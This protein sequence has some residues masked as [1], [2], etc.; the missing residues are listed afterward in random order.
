MSS[1]SNS[2]VTEEQSVRERY[3][4]ASQEAEPALCCPVEYPTELLKIIPAEIIER[5]Y[6]CGDPSP[7]V[8]PGDT[9]LDLGSGG[10]KLC[11][12]AA[13][14]VGAEGKVIGVDCNPDMLALARKYQGE[15]AE[16]IGHANVEF[17]C[18]MIQDLG[19]DLERLSSQLAE[20]NLS[21][22]ELLLQQR[23]IEQQIR[24]EQPL[25]ESDSVDCVVSNCVLN[26]VRPADR[27][28]LFQEIFRVLKKGGRAAISD[29]VA[30]EDIPQH[31]QDDP[32][33]WSG[34][35]SGAWRED[36][37]IA[38]FERAGFH[39]M[40]IEKRQSEPWQTVEGI[41]FRSVTVV[42]WKGKQGK[43]LE[44]NQSLIYR[45]PFKEVH[46]DDGH[47]YRRGERIAVCDKTYNLL[48]AGPYAGQFIPVA[49]YQD[50]PIEQAKEMD[51]RRNVSRHARETKGRSYDLTQLISEDC[52]GTTD[53]C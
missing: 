30:D 42:A 41:E 33:L 25:I 26:L 44:R 24:K 34:C 20:A 19:L 27:Q 36:E 15:V 38:E 4:N 40:H 2:T 5:D 21:G 51:C 45:G 1:P 50:I 28:Q 17:R 3:S 14:I 43:C 8:K 23:L 12:I 39:G 37:F 7:F 47:I 48:Q 18:G 6:G 11:Y 53:C 16:K 31:L 35:I 52:C 49:P 10:G 13:Q 32:T 29:I 22:V 46:D 9:V